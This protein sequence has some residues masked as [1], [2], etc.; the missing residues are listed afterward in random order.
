MVFSL[1]FLYGASLK[2]IATLGLEKIFSTYYGEKRILQLVY[3][4]QKCE[5][6]EGFYSRENL[7]LHWREKM[8]TIKEIDI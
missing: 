3:L 2:S 5:C 4:R 1:S 8:I 6:L 7:A